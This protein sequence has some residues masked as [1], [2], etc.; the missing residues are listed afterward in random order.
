MPT[1][2]EECLSLMFYENCIASLTRYQQDK[3]V[4][5]LCHATWAL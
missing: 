4:L 3:I 1:Q 2:F 5:V